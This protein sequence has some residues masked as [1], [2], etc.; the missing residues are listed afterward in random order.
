[1]SEVFNLA[2]QRERRRPGLEQRQ[3]LAPQHCDICNRV[4]LDVVDMIDHYAA[5]IC[6]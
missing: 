1:M 6:S 2:E 5:A 4:F 3:R